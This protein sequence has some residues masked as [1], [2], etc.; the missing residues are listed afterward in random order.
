LKIISP[1]TKAVGAGA[2]WIF[3]GSFSFG[4]AIGGQH[5]GVVAS[6]FTDGLAETA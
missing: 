5:F 4:N 3:T 1:S 6:R 2:Y